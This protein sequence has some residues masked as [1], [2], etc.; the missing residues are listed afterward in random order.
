[1]L[2]LMP[3][4]SLV[5]CARRPRYTWPKPPLPSFLSTMYSGL[6]PTC[7]CITA[8]ATA[9]AAARR[10]A[11]ERMCTWGGSPALGGT[12]DSLMAPDHPSS[13]ASRPE[14]SGLVP[15]P[16]GGAAVP[17]AVVRSSEN[18]VGGGT[19]HLL[20][21][22]G[23]CGLLLGVGLL[24]LALR[25]HCARLWAPATGLA[26]LPVARKRVQGRAVVCCW[27][28][29]P[30]DRAPGAAMLEELA[31]PARHTQCC[32]GTARCQKT[33]QVQRNR[34]RMQCRDWESARGPDDR[35]C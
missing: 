30:C 9:A 32:A 26:P 31:A 33:L 35:K 16:K 10:A 14:A 1:M 8:K 23:V 21:D 24:R 19:A 7:T 17:G 20:R 13:R 3:S 15:S 2:A 29:A 5:G 18:G 34:E 11:R 27:F 12:L 28:T 6:P 25:R 22:G 4:F